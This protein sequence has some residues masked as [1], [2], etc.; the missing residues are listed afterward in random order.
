MANRLALSLR[1]AVRSR[2]G[3][4]ILDILVIASTI[5][6]TMAHWSAVRQTLSGIAYDISTLLGSAI[7]GYMGASLWLQ[8]LI[9][10]V[11]VGVVIGM[12]ML[13]ASMGAL[14]VIASTM[15]PL[16]LLALFCVAFLSLQEM[17]SGSLGVTNGLATVLSLLV[18]LRLFFLAQVFPT[19]LRVLSAQP[20]AV[21]DGAFE[22]RRYDGDFGFGEYQDRKITMI[23]HSPT[24]NI[25]TSGATDRPATD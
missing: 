19:R 16:G 2:L 10:G 23:E 7:A 25:S 14:S 13:F 21:G 4:S 5:S 3:L 18:I 8:I 24:I 6:T 15:M 12:F 9:F 1:G 11:I 17:F 22:M 20:L